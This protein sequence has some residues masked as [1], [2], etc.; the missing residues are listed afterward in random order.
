M[1]G[2]NKFELSVKLSVGQYIP[3]GSVI[4]RLDPR[5]KLIMGMLLIAA[6]IISNSLL[7]L[8][9]LF[10]CVTF[11]LVAAR[12]QVKLA[13]SA[14]KPVMPFLLVLALIQVFAIPQYKSS[15]VIL[16]QWRILKIS[17]Q[18][19]LAGLLLIGR[20]AVIVLGLSLFSF[21]TST[22]ELLH[23]IEHLLRPLQKI[24]FPAHELAL[25][26]N[27]AIRFLPII[28]A[29]TEYLMKA[30]AS[31]GA[32]FGYGR[33]NFIKRIRSMLPLFVPLFVQ[34]LRYAFKLVEAMESRGYTGGKGR[35]YLISMHAGFVDF[36]G[37]AAG[38]CVIAAALVM[39]FLKI[40]LTV[41]GWVGL[42]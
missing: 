16:W 13:I 35:T 20:F 21:S 6:S 32:D 25:V 38:M 26:L 19:L 17:D 34:S 1:R 5:V 33:R 2:N 9:F 31:R 40:D 23:G 37:L 28:T 15:A 11:C 14:L 12:I 30:Q 22:T 3:T 7:S 10:V 8:V 29:E 36:G 39:S 41:L 4:H 18:S 27:I 24:K 42:I